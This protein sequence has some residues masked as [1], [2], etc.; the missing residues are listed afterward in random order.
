M[1][2][3]L[4]KSNNYFIWL[5]GYHIYNFGCAGKKAHE[6]TIR[7]SGKN[8]C[9]P[10]PPPPPKKKR[11]NRSHT[12]MSLWTYVWVLELS[13]KPNFFFFYWVPGYRV[14]ATPG[15]AG[16]GRPPLTISARHKQKTKKKS[17][18]HYFF[19][20][21][22]FLVPFFAKDTHH[23]AREHNYFLEKCS[24]PVHCDPF[25]RTAIRAPISELTPAQ[26]L[27][28]CARH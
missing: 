24:E 10:P 4:L 17:A 11:I 7:D 19:F 15:G 5:S 12:P 1:R 20:F 3:L 14:L 22:F 21:F 8:V 25:G 28:G 2:F 18:R 9:A 26:T 23:T 6:C 27:L 13:S 16:R